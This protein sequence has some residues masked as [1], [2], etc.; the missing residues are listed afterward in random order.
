M[1]QPAT[2][3]KLE[4]RVSIY[5][6]MHNSQEAEFV[7]EFLSLLHS[8]CAFSFCVLSISGRQ[9][10][11]GQVVTTAIIGAQEGWVS[12]L[13]AKVALKLPDYTRPV[14]SVND[15]HPDFISRSIVTR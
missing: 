2:P 14:I 5:H 6:S 7:R 4:T 8:E 9:N 3:T 12:A 15:R 13:I 10:R 11:G 1:W